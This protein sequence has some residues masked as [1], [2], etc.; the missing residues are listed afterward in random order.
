MR[1]R[2]FLRDAALVAA[3]V[4]SR[5][6]W[7]QDAIPATLTVDES[8]MLATLPS[9]FVGLSYESAQLANPAF[10]A[11][12]NKGLIALLREMGT[13]GVLRIGGGTSEF[14]AFTTEDVKGPPPFDA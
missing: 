8:T 14:T 4:G 7:A 3:A 6:T 5:S 9:D 1:R 12:E 11:A 2:E 13:Q 10:F